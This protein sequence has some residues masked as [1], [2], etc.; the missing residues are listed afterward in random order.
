PV[1][2]ARR[3]SRRA[4][5]LCRRIWHR[6]RR[7]FCSPSWR[8]READRPCRFQS[9]LEGHLAVMAA[10]IFERRD[11]ERSFHSAEI[12]HGKLPVADLPA[13]EALAHQC[14][15]SPTSAINPYRRLSSVKGG[16]PCTSPSTHSAPSLV[17][18]E[19]RPPVT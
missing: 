9:H 5:T 6:S 1:R 13:K 17:L 14:S 18:P 3:A 15:V 19:P 7:A 11:L 8:H 2:P 12:G 16:C 10:G 4:G